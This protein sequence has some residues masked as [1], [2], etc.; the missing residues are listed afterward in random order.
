[1]LNKDET[2]TCLNGNIGYVFESNNNHHRKKNS[3]FYKIEGCNKCN[4]LS[5]C[6]RFMKEKNKNENY[7]IFEVSIQLQK[8]IQE[9]QTNLLSIEGIEMRVNRSIQVEGAFGIIKQNFLYDR[10]RRR[11][12]DKINVEFMLVCLGV[13]IRKLFKFFDNKLDLTFWKAPQDIKVESFKKPNAKRLSNKA[14]KKNN[15]SINQKSK[16]SYKYSK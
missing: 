12:L 10:F 2:I 13:N 11:K 7:K 4:F 8:Y 9:S 16:D 6:K 5:Y 15:K 14:N 3:V 1:M